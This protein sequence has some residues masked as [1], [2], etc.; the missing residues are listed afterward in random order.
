MLYEERLITIMCLVVETLHVFL[1]IKIKVLT[2]ALLTLVFIIIFTIHTYVSRD[3]FRT[4]S[5]KLNNF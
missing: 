2:P 5:L 1:T 3:V 4:V